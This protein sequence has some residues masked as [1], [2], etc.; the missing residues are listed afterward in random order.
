MRVRLQM[1]AET[2]TDQKQSLMV[3]QLPFVS[4][5][6]LIAPP[7]PRA[8]PTYLPYEPSHRAKLRVTRALLCLKGKSYETYRYLRGCETPEKEL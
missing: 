1:G 4:A 7:S 3:I 8:F 2:I 6:D 5:C